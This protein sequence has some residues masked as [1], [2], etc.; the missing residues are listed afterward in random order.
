MTDKITTFG[1]VALPSCITFGEMDNILHD[2]AGWFRDTLTVPSTTGPR[3]VDAIFDG[4]G[5]AVHRMIV[6]D[7]YGDGFC[8]SDAESG[9]RL[10]YGGRVFASSDYA[11]K[12]AE[13]F[14][15][16]MFDLAY[17]ARIGST[18]A[19]Q[20]RETM[21]KAHEAAERRGETLSTLVYPSGRA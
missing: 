10:S 3:E 15:D 7:G 14:F 17:C 8:I 16:V 2:R 12:M 4:K 5:L 9:L 6:E 19:E 20:S 13:D 11:A 18:L 1:V 21:R